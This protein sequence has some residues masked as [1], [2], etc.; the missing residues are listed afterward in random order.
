MRQETYL[1]PQSPYVFLAVPLQWFLFCTQIKHKEVLHSAFISITLL[2]LPTNGG[3]VGV[4]GGVTANVVELRVSGLVKD[5]L[6][7]VQT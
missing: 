3:V 5:R 2:K 6:C 1:S 4:V 7:E